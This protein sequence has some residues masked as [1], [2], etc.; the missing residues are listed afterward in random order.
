LPLHF[1]TLASFTWIMLMTGDGN[2]PRGF[3]G[4]HGEGAQ[5]TKDMSLKPAV[6]PQ[7]V[8]YQFTWQASYDLPM[9]KG[10]AL[11]LNGLA[12]GVLRGW[13]ANSVLYRS[14]RIPVASPTFGIAPSHF[15]QITGNVNSLRQFQ[16]GARFTF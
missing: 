3:I 4:A 9:G 7:D 14:S 16:H 10:R 1:T 11:N 6:S 13:T 8:K 2:P 12:N 15:S 5:G